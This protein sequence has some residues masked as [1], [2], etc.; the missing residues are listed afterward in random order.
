MHLTFIKT[1]ISGIL[2]LEAFSCFLAVGDRA[3]EIV[4]AEEK[5]VMLMFRS[6]RS[7]RLKRFKLS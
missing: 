1:Y 7:L 5:A 3:R 2:C 4:W 6:R